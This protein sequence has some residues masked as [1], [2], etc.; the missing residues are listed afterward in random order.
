MEKGI[1]YVGLDVHKET[2]TVAQLQGS[3][4]RCETFRVEN[5]PRALR[6]LIRELRR[7]EQV[8]CCY[9]AG[10]CGYEVYREWSAHGVPCAV[11]VPSRIPRSPGDRVKNDHRD[12]ESLAR[13][14]RAE[15]LEFVRPPTTAQEAVRD[16]VRAREDLRHQLMATRHRLA[17]FVLRYGR[18]YGEGTR[19]TPRYLRWLDSQQ[20]DAPSAQRAFEEYRAQLEF[21]GQ[22]QTAIES[23]LLKVAEEPPYRQDVGRITCLRGFRPLSG[24]LLLAELVDVRRFY[25]GPALAGY[26]G[27]GCVESSSGGRQWRGPITKTG[28]THARRLLIEAAWAY[29]FRPS[30]RGRV[31]RRLEG[32]APEVV[33]LSWQAQLRL[34]SR[35]RHLIACGKKPQVAVVGV[36][37]ELCSFVW[38][39]IN[40]PGS[41]RRYQG[42]HQ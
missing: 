27:L 39:V 29:R 19:W 17:K 11:V 16:L 18:R 34:H 26:V 10:P 1:T 33:A 40:D 31:Q 32:H 37:R 5:T 7:K 42:G 30:L 4:N 8:R 12:A 21:L 36:A 23:D 2:I 24:I 15:M 35:Y 28:N 6:R 13:L 9:E 3:S 14:L 41:C 22:R 38:A 20:F 25:S